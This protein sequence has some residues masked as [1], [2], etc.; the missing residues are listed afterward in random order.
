MCTG[1]KIFAEQKF[2]NFQIPIPNFQILIYKQ[3]LPIL[4]SLPANR[5]AQG[6]GRRA[7]TIPQA[8]DRAGDP[9]LIILINSFFVY[10]SGFPLEFNPMAIG[11]GMTVGVVKMT[12]KYDFPFADYKL[13]ITSTLFTYLA[14]L[15]YRFK[16]FDKL[17]N[18]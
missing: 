9:L 1:N 13:L 14:Y 17:P 5:C 6:A 10:L 18:F 16:L 4:S 15:A 12:E 2:Y 11:A 3:G 8:R 7:R